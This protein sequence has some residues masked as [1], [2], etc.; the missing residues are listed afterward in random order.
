[1]VHLRRVIAKDGGLSKDTKSNNINYVVNGVKAKKRRLLTEP[2]SPA[3][4]LV[5]QQFSVTAQNLEREL[6]S[7]NK[8][9]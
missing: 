7:L 3:T 1:M 9:L 2:H 4:E 5:N 6:H 8:E